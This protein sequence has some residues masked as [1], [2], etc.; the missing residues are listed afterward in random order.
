MARYIDADKFL[1]DQ[2]QRCGC[3][4]LIGTCTM[5]NESLKDIVERTPTSDVKEVKRSKWVVDAYDNQDNILVIDYIAHEHSMP[6]CF[7]CKGEA[8]LDGGEEYVASDFCPHCGADMR[9]E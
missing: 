6:Y 9:G 8:L 1:E 5:D 2:I 7:L 4:P 3:V